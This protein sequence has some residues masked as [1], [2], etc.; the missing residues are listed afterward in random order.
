[1]PPLLSDR[2]LSPA[3]RQSLSRARKRERQREALEA[4]EAVI[5]APP[6][7]EVRRAALRAL[8]AT[9]EADGRRSRLIPRGE[10]GGS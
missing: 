1:M 9:Y 3:E 10:A 6:R 2:P 7:A 8:L 5:T 4:L